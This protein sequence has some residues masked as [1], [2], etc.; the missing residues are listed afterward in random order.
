[1][2]S[3]KNTNI[4]LVILAVVVL[5]IIFVYARGTGTQDVSSGLVAQNTSNSTEISAFLRRISAIRDVRL[6]VSVF[7]NPV[8]RNGLK[9]TSQELFPEEKGR[10][11]PFAP[12]SGMSASVVQGV[13]SVVPQATA[14]VVV[15]PTKVLSD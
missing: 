13:S 11:N 6:D 1:M 15:P 12:I 2:Q 7:D 10:P 8:L 3:N 9:D 4:I 5:V 14:P